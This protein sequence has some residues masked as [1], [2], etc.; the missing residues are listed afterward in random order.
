MV[1]KHGEYVFSGPTQI[2]G[3]SAAECSDPVDVLRSLEN[4]LKGRLPSKGEAIE[5]D[6]PTSFSF[7]EYRK[8]ARTLLSALF[9]SLSHVVPSFTLKDTVPDVLLEPAGVGWDRVECLP[10]ELALHENFPTKAFFRHCPEKGDTVMDFVDPKNEPLRLCFSADEGTEACS[11]KQNM[12]YRGHCLKDPESC[13]ILLH[14]PGVNH[15]YPC[16]LTLAMTLIPFL[17]TH[18]HPP[19]Q[20]VVDVAVLFFGGLHDLLLAR[21]LSQ[22]GQTTGFMFPTT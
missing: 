5:V 13:C 6:A 14:V 8:T 9:N 16:F 15:I 10:E 2:L 19:F 18:L 12:V 1:F 17:F 4:V 3:D 20:G 11:D 21:R 7:R 22:D